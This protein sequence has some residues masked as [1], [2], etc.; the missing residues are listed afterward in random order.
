MTSKALSTLS[1]SRRGFFLFVEEEGIDEFAHENNGTHMLQA[2]GEL[3]KAV[4]VAR[5]Y[6]ATRPDTLVV[7]TGD[8]ECGGLTVEDTATTDESG[9]GISAEDGPF[10]IKGSPLTFNLDWTTTGHTGADVPVTAY[11]TLA[12]EFTGKPPD[13]YVHD[14]LT[15][16][17]TR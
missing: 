13:T 2:V 10:R 8:H 3:E 5:T 4:A 11:G 12:D 7:V 16:A 17:L 14:V 1:T 15:H 6:A 9:D